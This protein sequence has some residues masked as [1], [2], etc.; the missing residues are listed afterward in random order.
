MGLLLAAGRRASTTSIT[1]SMRASVAAAFLR[2][3]AMWPGN[4]WT[5]MLLP[6][7]RVNRKGQ[8]SMPGLAARACVKKP[9]VNRAK[10]SAPLPDPAQGKDMTD[11]LAWFA[12][13]RPYRL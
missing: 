5:D 4:H 1:M 13:D 8:T 11:D 3:A 6:E 12:S 2:A 9:D 10:V 7:L